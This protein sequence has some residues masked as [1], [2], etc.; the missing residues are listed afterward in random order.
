MKRTFLLTYITTSGKNYTEFK[1]FENGP[2][3]DAC[4]QRLIDEFDELAYL[5][6]KDGQQSHYINVD[7]IESLSIQ[8]VTE[9]QN[10]MYDFNG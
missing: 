10:V 4:I 2:D 5:F 7:H 9:G 8:E 1:T 6:L 3:K